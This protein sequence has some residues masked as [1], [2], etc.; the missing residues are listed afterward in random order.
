MTLASWFLDSL[1]KI[2][3]F[4]FRLVCCSTY[5]CI[6]WLILTCTLTGDQT[7]NLGILVQCSNQLSCYLAGLDSYSL[8]SSLIPGPRALD[9]AIILTCSGFSLTVSGNIIWQ[10]KRTCPP[11]LTA[12]RIFFFFLFSPKDNFSLLFRER[13]R[14]RERHQSEREASVDCLLYA[15]ILGTK[16]ASQACALAG[17][18][19]GD[20][21]L[22][23]MTLNQLTTPVRAA[24]LIQEILHELS[25]GRKS[26]RPETWA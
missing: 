18:W 14:G 8:N 26:W 9:F 16:S 6:H 25:P 24:G 5:L 21:S 13:G 1:K 22:C 15:P 19:T 11:R 12:F 23:G 7:Y 20:L 17:N 2:Y 10:L 4:F 3:W